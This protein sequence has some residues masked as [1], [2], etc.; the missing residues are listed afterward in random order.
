MDPTRTPAHRRESQRDPRWPGIAA[1][2]AAGI[3]GAAAASLLVLHGS[4]AAFTATTDNN[5]NSVAAGTVVLTDDDSDTKLFDIAAANGG[6][7]FTRCINVEYTGSLDADIKLFGNPAGDLAPGITATVDVGTGATGG[8]TFSCTGFTQDDAGTEFSGA[9]ST[10]PTTYA[11][12]V[13][14]NDNASDPTVKSYRIVFTL[15]NDNQYQG[16]SATVS[17]TWEAQ[18][19][20]A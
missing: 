6:Q 14:E 5:D 17:F 16:D 20:D 7:S 15:S 19:Q 2:V 3:I 18:G 9:L 11:A 13:G 1:R 8:T 4:D 10:F 12:G